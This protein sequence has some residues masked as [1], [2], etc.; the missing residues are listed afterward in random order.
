MEAAKS[1]LTS[2]GQV[3]LP[4]AARDALALKPGDEVEFTM[5]D[6]KLVLRKVAGESPF[7]RWA[8]FLVHLKGQDPDEL[9]EEMRGR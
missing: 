9:V 6:G 8:G 5:D 3:T 7:D 4:K 2:K 1:K